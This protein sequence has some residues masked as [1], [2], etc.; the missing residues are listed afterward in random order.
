MLFRRILEA[1]G[2]NRSRSQASGEKRGVLLSKSKYLVGLQCPKALWINYKDKALLPEVDASTEALFDQGHQVG[3]LAQKLFP[4][5][6]DV[7]HLSGFDEPVRATRIALSAKKPLFEAAFIYDRCFS[8]ADI[9]EPVGDGDWDIIEVKSATEVKEVNISDLAFQRYVYEGNGLSIRNCYILYINN[10]YFRS[11]IVDPSGLF[12]KIDVTQAVTEL[13]PAVEPKVSEM[14]QVIDSDF[15][16]QIKISPHC[17]SPYECSLKP[18][19]WKF[20]PQPNVFNLRRPGKKPWELLDQTIFRLEEIPT[21]FTLNEVQSR[22]IASHR[23]GMPHIDAAAI[24]TFLQRLSYPFYFLDFET[25]GPAIPLYDRSRPYVQIPFQFSLHR[26]EF[27]GALPTHFEF[28]A[29]GTGDPRP[30][31]LLR[32]KNLLG[33]SGSII[34]YNVDFEVACL[35]GCAEAFPEYQNWF[36]SLLPRFVDLYDVFEDLS[37]YHPSQ[38]GGASLKAVLPALTGAGYDDLDITSGDSA[39]REF[40]R[41][42]FGDV[43]PS[44][45]LKI[46]AALQAYCFRDT[47]GLVDILEAL[48]KLIAEPAAASHG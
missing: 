30:D 4:S 26:V 18:I 29:D 41:I 3:L 38:N 28:L 46:R 33:H 45:R 15:C 32:L 24:R 34:G 6:I 20:L 35:K 13:M 16:P 31:V 2:F 8:R 14:L 12:S 1:L 23:S 7:G 37:Y 9:L 44:E 36:D 25:I 43:T 42:A 39:Q 22:Q 5:G 40:I 10:R 27:E 11:G 21:D 19:C 47:R 17:N 48:K